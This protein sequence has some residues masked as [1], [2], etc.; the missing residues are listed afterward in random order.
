M[1]VV[2][3]II[4]VDPDRAARYAR[5]RASS[6]STASATNISK[7]SKTGDKSS[8]S[9]IPRRDRWSAVSAKGFRSR[10]RYICI[11]PLPWIGK[12]D[13]DEDS[14]DGCDKGKSCLCHKPAIEHPEHIWVVSAAGYKKFLAL[15][16]LI[17]LRDPDNFQ[18]YTFNDHSGYGVIEAIENYILDFIEAEGNWKEQWVVCEA[19]ALIL[20]GNGMMPMVMVGDS[21][22]VT[23]IFS[24][25]VR[26]VLSV[27]AKLEGLELLKPDSE[28]RNLSLVMAL[29]IEETGSFRSDGYISAD[30]PERRSKTFKFDAARFDN[31]LVTYARK[32]NIKPQG[33]PDTDKNVEKLDDIELPAAGKDPW[34]WNVALKKYWRDYGPKI[35]GDDLD[36]TTF[37]GKD[38]LSRKEIQAIKDGMVMQMM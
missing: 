6:G 35:G 32:Y 19:L 20:S 9:D 15:D 10:L 12:E 13:D 28:V 2:Y 16:T 3:R 27:L 37:T 8:S 23:A 34:G 1:S 17:S 11:C 31:Y 21:E 22:K 26:M 33:L 30:E 5:K 7:K 14:V 29:Y 25:I 18:M 24:I 36:I 4:I 38:P